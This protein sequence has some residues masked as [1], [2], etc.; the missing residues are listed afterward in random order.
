MY[1]FQLNAQNDSILLV[2]RDSL[3]SITNIPKWKL[4]SISALNGT[5]TTLK[6]WNSGGKS[7]ISILGFIN[8]SA[9][10]NN[11]NVKWEN[12]ISL[13]LGGVRY[14]NNAE[15][16][17]VVQKTDD[18][19][20]ISTKFGYHLNK[21]KYFSIISGLKTQSLVGYNFPNDSVRISNFMA[22]G[23]LN[24]AIG[25]DYVTSDNFGIFISPFAAKMTFVRDQNLANQGAFGVTKASYNDIGQ[26]IQ[27]G[28]EFRGE[29]GAYF[30]IK[31]NKAIAKNIEFKSKL[32][33]F[34]NYNH[35]PQN[36]DVNAELLITFKVNSWFSSSI[37]CN[38]IYDDDVLI[39]NNLGKAS[40]KCQIKS[41]IG[42]GISY[43]MKN[44]KEK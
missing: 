7:S 37:L 28:K 43:T 19:I 11:K 5:Q 33:L 18:K 44:F 22:P 20:D 38:A 31:W 41:I 8:T 9:Y 3:D 34:S 25:Y 6:N 21:K 13:S 24:S 17:N 42:M 39:T 40:P 36:I 4:K 30:K 1:L 35:N 29:F 12:D 15:K 27:N 32:D 16:T 23:Y 14:F 10:Y 2:K 26:I